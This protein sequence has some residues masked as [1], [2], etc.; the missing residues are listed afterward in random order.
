MLKCKCYKCDKS[1]HDKVNYSVWLN[2]LKDPLNAICK[3]TFEYQLISLKR[4]FK[5]VGTFTPNIPASIEY[6]KLEIDQLEE[7]Q[8]ENESNY[9]YGGRA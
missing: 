7:V 6:K 4:K 8:K 1:L 9:Y 5:V 2:T 3:N